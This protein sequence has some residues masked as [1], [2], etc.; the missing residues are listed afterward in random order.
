MTSRIPI[1]IR[2]PDYPL[3]GM[4]KA[5]FMSNQS[6]RNLGFTIIEVLVTVAII[7]ILA[8][9]LVPTIGSAIRKAQEGQAMT[10]C[11][12][13][14]TA[15]Q[16]YHMSYG[17]LPVVP[18]EQGTND[19]FYD[20]L[21]SKAIIAVLTANETKLNPRKIVFLESKSASTNGVMLDPWGGQYA[22][23][24]DNNY[25]QKVGYF[26]GTNENITKIAIGISFG[27]NGMQENP[28]TGDDIVSY[29]E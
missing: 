19:L 17:K 28:A 22:I 3:V 26:S 10:E 25:N 14:A 9:M 29:Q 27:I 20:Q 4:Y 8:G 21:D 18:R 15:I 12:A 7:V 5:W 2:E 23:K 13:I 11:M 6:H 24:L 16:Q 1:G